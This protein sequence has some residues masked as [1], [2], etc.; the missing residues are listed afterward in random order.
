MMKPVL[1]GLILLLLL[2]Q[3]ELWFSNGGIISTI[4]LKHRITQQK[5]ENKILEKRNKVL[6]ADIKELKEGNEA[7]E[8]RARS[9]LGMIKKGETFYQIVKHE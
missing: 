4:K 1:I 7:V 8:G 5:A 3:Y 6:M 9:E 2:L